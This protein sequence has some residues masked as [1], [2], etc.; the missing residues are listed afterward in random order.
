MSDREHREYD[1]GEGSLDPE[2]LYMKE[3]CI[4]SSLLG[5]AEYQLAN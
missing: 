5:C 3:Y 2:L 4:G 1:D